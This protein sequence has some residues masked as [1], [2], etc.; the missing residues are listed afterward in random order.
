MAEPVR[1][2]DLR[3]TDAERSAV[4]QRLHRAHEAGQLDLHEFDDRVRSVWARA[5]A[6]GAALAVLYAAGI[7]RPGAD[8]R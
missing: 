5:P 2:A 8:H 1:P 6:P 7:G 4:Q 3:V